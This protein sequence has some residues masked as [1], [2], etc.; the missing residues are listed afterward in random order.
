MRTPRSLVLVPIL[1]LWLAAAGCQPPQAAPDS[2]MPGQRIYESKCA[3]CHL[4]W[5]VRKFAPE[6]WPEKVDEFGPRA[7]LTPEGKRK[8][9]EYLQAASRKAAAS[10]TSP[11]NAPPDPVAPS[12]SR[13]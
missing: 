2:A 7:G 5:P 11:P 10:Q 3:R 6:A 8:V 4:P 13:E 9:V 1:P 12:N